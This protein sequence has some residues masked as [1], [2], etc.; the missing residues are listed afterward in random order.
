M[1]MDL[2]EMARNLEMEGKSVYEHGIKL[3][4][5]ENVKKILQMLLKVEETHFDLFIEIQKNKKPG[6]IKHVDFKIARQ[7]F[8]ALKN[9]KFSNEQVKCFE[10]MLATEKK[11]EDYYTENANGNQAI[12]EIAKEEHRHYVLI[13]EMM[14]LL[15]KTKDY[16]E[17]EDFKKFDNY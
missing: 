4:K 2:F 9:E 6:P 7:V 13:K 14:D 10:K 17:S 12:L 1:A 11:S 15:K 16:R 3:N 5:S 8:A